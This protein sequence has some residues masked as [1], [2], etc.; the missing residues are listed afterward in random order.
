MQNFKMLEGRGKKG[1]LF[2][3]FIDDVSQ[4]HSVNV[5][6]DSVQQFSYNLQIIKK[7]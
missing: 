7:K 6:Q 4:M 1:S 3:Y 2:Y 5:H